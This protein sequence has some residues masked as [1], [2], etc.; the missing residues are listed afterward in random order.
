MK[1][2]KQKDFKQGRAYRRKT[3]ALLFFGMLVLISLLELIPLE[4][5]FSEKENRPLATR[6]KLSLEHVADGSFMAQYE[7]FRL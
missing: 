3:A 7:E 4:Q 6:P 1:Q 2:R 5:E